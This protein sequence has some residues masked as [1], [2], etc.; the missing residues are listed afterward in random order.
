MAGG[1]G[2]RLRPLTSNQPKPM[3]P[4]CGKPCIE[5]IIELLHTHG[6]EDVV[7]TLAFLPQ[8]IRGYLGDGSALGVS[9]DYSVEETPLGTAGSVKNAEKL[10]DETFVV[11]SGDALCDFDLTRIVEFHKERGSVATIALK[12]VDNPL[13]FGVVI[14]DEEGRIERF[15]EKP[16][17]GQVFSDTINTG[18]YVLE[19]EVLRHVPEDEPYDFSKQ[20]FPYLLEAQKPMYGFVVDDDWYWQDIGNLDQYRQANQDVLDG[21]C[22][23]QVPGIRLRSNIWLGQ[24]V[25]LPPAEVLE[26]PAYLGNYC[27]IEE[28]ARVG[29]YAVLGPNVTVKV[30]AAVERT[31][32]DGGTYIGNGADIAGAII[33]RNV[34]VH[35]RVRV[36]EGVAIGDECTIGA[37]AVISPNLRIYPYKTIEAGANVQQ[38]LIWESR[39]VSTLFGR[40]GVSGIVNVDVT[41]EA[42]V[43]IGLALGTH[44]SIG[45]RVAASR[46]SHPASQ[47]IKEALV[48]G[49]VASGVNVDDLSSVP[50]ALTRREIRS[51]RKPGG[52]HVSLRD[53]ERVEVLLLEKGGLLASDGMRRDVEKH[54]GRQEFRRASPSEIGARAYTSRAVDSY[55]SEVVTA[56]DLEAVRA[57]HFRVV[58]DHGARSGAMIAPQVLAALGVEVITLGARGDRETASAQLERLVTAAAADVGATLDAAAER[59]WI[60]DELARPLA[61]ELL[62]LLFTSLAVRRGLAGRIAVPTSATDHVDRI[63]EGSAITVTRTIA[64]AAALARAAAEPDVI[65]AG[66]DRAGIAFGSVLPAYDGVAALAKL[67]DWLAPETEP[68]HA[69]IDALPRPTLTHTE[70]YC[71][72][73]AKGTVMRTLIE[74]AKGLETDNLDGLKVREDSHW[75]QLMPDSD[76]PLFHVFA[77][78]RDENATASL[79]GRYRTR[80][81]ELIAAATPGE[82]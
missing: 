71:P 70:I 56:V 65:F 1:E 59:L 45:D 3:V 42:A 28:G 53:D 72:W 32:I 75:V 62:L 36:R 39:G 68:L 61:S 63:V 73:S 29:P 7:V 82:I 66:A 64:S 30:G 77:E 5:H 16:S 10:L 26:G 58:V 33:G 13:E 19:P 9:L 67:L 49:L 48:A 69:L 4:I 35:E 15:L 20:L 52:F 34:D 18:V 43:K 25:T 76:R 23:V 50:P 38:S 12:S 27:R 47:M 31:I 81:E 46:D 57:R 37:E 54:F 60:V 40:D 41:P 21:R 79:L 14:V 78:A 17:W 8:A 6:I 11:I 22:A 55:V 51:A 74:D 2:T 44:M 80:V 24:G